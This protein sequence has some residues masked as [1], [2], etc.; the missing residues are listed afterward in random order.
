MPLHELQSEEFVTTRQELRIAKDEYTA[1]KV[2]KDRRKARKWLT[3]LLDDR[4]VVVFYKTG[5]GEAMT[6]GTRKGFDCDTSN[7]P[8]DIEVWNNT[9]H[10]V[11]N[12][13]LFFEMPSQKPVAVHIDNVTKFICKKDGIIDISNSVQW[14]DD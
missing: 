3:A 11:Q 2:Q 5:D 7:I 9:E 6:L 4:E 14:V 8:E 10:K 1:R 13:V 12:H